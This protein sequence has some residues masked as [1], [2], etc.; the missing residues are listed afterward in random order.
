MLRD[1]PL[2]AADTP[3]ADRLTEIEEAHIDA[4]FVSLSRARDSREL[5]GDHLGAL[6]LADV[7]DKLDA[8]CR[9]RAL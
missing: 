8:V 9:E 6:R 7:I 1:Y 4:A 5:T 2:P 3:L